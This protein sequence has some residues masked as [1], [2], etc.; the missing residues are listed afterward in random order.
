[1]ILNT[2]IIKGIPVS[3]VNNTCTCATLQQ[4]Q[5][6]KYSDLCPVNLEQHDHKDVDTDINNNEVSSWVVVEISLN[7]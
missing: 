3:N 4:N 5:S 1:M 2:V 7:F 6:R